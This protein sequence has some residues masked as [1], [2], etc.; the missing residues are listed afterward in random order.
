MIEILLPVYN[1][2]KYLKEQIESF[3]NQTNQDW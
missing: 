3:F 2:E 1:G